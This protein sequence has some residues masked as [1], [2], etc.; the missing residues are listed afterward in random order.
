M[1]DHNNLLRILLPDGINDDSI[2]TQVP[3]IKGQRILLISGSKIIVKRFSCIGKS[4]H[5]I[6]IQKLIVCQLSDNRI[7]LRPILFFH[8]SRPCLSLYMLRNSL[9]F[10]ISSGIGFPVLRS[11]WQIF[12][13]R[14]LFC[15]IRI[16][17]RSAS[18]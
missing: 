1:S 9:S 15:P 12:S 17:Y 18:S 5:F 3:C 10:S 14:C 6:Q 16:S 8:K 13:T 2:G 4:I 11:F 7:F